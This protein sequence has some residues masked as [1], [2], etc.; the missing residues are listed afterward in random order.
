MTR[1]AHGFMRT[2]NDGSFLYILLDVVDER[3]NDPPIGD[4]YVLAFDVDLNR[5]VTPNVD[6]IYDDHDISLQ[7]VVLPAAMGKGVCL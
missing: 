5:T 7:R 6:L 3:V 4:F 1:L 2:M